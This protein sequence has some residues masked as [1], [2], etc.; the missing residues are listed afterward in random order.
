MQNDKATAKR[1]RKP[2][3][4]KLPVAPVERF[5]GFSAGNIARTATTAAA[6][7]YPFDTASTRDDSY[8]AFFALAAREHGTGD[9]KR[10]VALTALASYGRNPLYSGSAKPHDAGAIERAS[11]RAHIAYDAEARTITLTEAG[12]EAGSAILTKL[13]KQA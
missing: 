11:K 6:M 5:G 2:K 13:A 12:A 4:D 7:R 3:A 10:T 8:T 1:T 9:N